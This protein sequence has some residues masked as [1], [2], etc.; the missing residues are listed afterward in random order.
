LSGKLELDDLTRF[1]S[2]SDPQ[3]SPDGEK[4]AFVTTSLDD[5]RDKYASTIWVIG[6][7]DGEPLQFMSGKSDRSP[8]WLPDGKQILFTSKRGLEEGERVTSSGL[9]RSEGGSPGSWLG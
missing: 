8:V 3:L 1:V 6:L 5:E 7:A 4:V 9:R 2:V